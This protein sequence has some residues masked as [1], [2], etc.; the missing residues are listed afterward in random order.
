MHQ[1]FL[2]QPSNPWLFN[3]LMWMIF[4]VSISHIFAGL[5]LEKINSDSKFFQTARWERGGQIYQDWFKVKS[6]K[7]KIPSLGA[8]TVKSYDLKTVRQ[9]S[10][11]ELRLWV[12]ESC[13][14]EL[15]HWA[16]IVPG[17]LFF[18]WNDVL[19]AWIMVAYAF[20]NNL[21]PIIMQR[22]N[23]P[24]VRRVLERLEQNLQT[25]ELMQTSYAEETIFNH[26]Q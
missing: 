6:W 18:L 14:A 1:F 16:L 11:D 9:M 10:L 22:Y 19:V 24:R 23:R 15:C 7:G 5:P 2:F 26:Y 13:R 21:I 4:H 17:F 3:I 8:K 12:K 20:A 25:Q